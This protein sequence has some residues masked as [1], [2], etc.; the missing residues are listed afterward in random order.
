MVKNLKRSIREKYKR[1]EAN[2]YHTIEDYLLHAEERLNEK[3]A[4]KIRNREKVEQITE[5]CREILMILPIPKEYQDIPDMN[6]EELL[7]NNC[8][9]EILKEGEQWRN[10]LSPEEL[11]EIRNFNDKK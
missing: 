3:L 1:R 7:A 9:D 11:K 10:N 2:L 8:I 6:I 5:K 4:G